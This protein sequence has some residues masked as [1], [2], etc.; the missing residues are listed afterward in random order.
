MKTTKPDWAIHKSQEYRLLKILGQN[1]P[2]VIDST[3]LKRAAGKL[4]DWQ[5]A[6]F[7]GAGLLELIPAN[8]K[9]A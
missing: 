4:I 1:G 7:N 8:K 3:T 6:R 5:L 2:Q 9:E